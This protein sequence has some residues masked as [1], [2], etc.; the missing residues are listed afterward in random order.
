MIQNDIYGL[1][2]K[3]KRQETIDILTR[4]KKIPKDILNVNTLLVSRDLL[5]EDF[6]GLKE[7]YSNLDN[8]IECR[9]SYKILFFQH[10]LTNSLNDEILRTE[11][12]DF[13]PHAIRCSFENDILKSTH[14]F[15]LVVVDLGINNFR[16]E[17]NNYFQGLSVSEFKNNASVYTTMFESLKTRQNRFDFI[18]LIESKKE[19]RIAKINLGKLLIKEYSQSTLTET[20]SLTIQEIEDIEKE[21]IKEKEEA[22]KKAEE[23]AKVI[24]KEVKK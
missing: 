16:K 18:N 7:A 24:V 9:N 4:L 2:K 20:E 3:I 14:D 19:R 6:V 10:F 1:F 21:L 5:Q 11:L 8:D 22:A 12:T 13:I 23:T 17:A 15:V